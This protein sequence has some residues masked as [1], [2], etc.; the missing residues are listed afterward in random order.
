MCVW[1]KQLHEKWLPN[2]H[3][4]YNQN[5]ATINY[6][7]N[8]DKFFTTNARFGNTRLSDNSRIRAILKVHHPHYLYP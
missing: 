5:S 3:F 2:V 8:Y 1:Q 7:E 6:R 4:F